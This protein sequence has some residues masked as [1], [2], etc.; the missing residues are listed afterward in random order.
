MSFKDSTIVVALSLLP[1]RLSTSLIGALAHSWLSRPLLRYYVW[2]EGVDLDEAERPALG[3]YADLSDL[4]TRALRPGARPID[5]DALLVAP[6][7]AEVASASPESSVMTDASGGAPPASSRTRLFSTHR[8]VGRARDGA[9]AIMAGRTLDLGELLKGVATPNPDDAV[10]V[11]YLSPR[12]YHRVHAPCDARLAAAAH[13]AGEL[14]PVKLSVVRAVEGVFQRN[15]RVAM[16]LDA[17][18]LPGLTLT[19]VA[20]LGVGHVTWP[21]GAVV[22]GAA[23]H[24]KAPFVDGHLAR[25]AELATFGL[26]STVIL[27]APGDAVD[28][29]V[30]IGQKIR[31]GEPVARRPAPPAALA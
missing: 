13:V 4:F 17:P 16:V 15:E 8:Y 10:A 30:E 11:F 18:E 20:A 23:A 24:E 9:A 2:S 21:G 1:K 12:D 29:C 5:G 3:D 14:F 19:M 31:V 26:G 25:G 22:D 7:D 27:T 6:C 28:W